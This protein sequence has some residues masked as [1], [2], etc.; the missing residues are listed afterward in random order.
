ML[1]HDLPV[2]SSGCADGT[3]ALLQALLG[4]TGVGAG[5]DFRSGQL[6]FD[7]D[8]NEGGSLRFAVGSIFD[9]GMV[10]SLEDGSSARNAK[11]PAASPI[12]ARDAALGPCSDSIFTSVGDDEGYDDGAMPTHTAFQKPLR[13][14]KL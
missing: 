13:L 1:V 11:Q 14:R 6:D 5:I 12:V 8:F 7:G 3:G 10:I 4:G 2:M 9:T